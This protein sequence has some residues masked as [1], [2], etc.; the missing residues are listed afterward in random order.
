MTRTCDRNDSE[1]RRIVQA[2]EECRLL[3]LDHENHVRVA[4]HNLRTDS[5]TTVLSEL[6]AKLKRYAASKSAPDIYHETITYAFVFIINERIN[7]HPD[8]GWQEFAYRNRDLFDSKVLLKFYPQGVL[9]SAFARRV[10][11]WPTS[12][13]KSS[14]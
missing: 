9:E 6:P 2:F 12:A 13:F 10:F 11:V 4:W 14:E 3:E 5:L 1:T 8:D 7:R